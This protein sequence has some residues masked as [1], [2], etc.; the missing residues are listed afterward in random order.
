[1]ETD[2]SFD[3]IKDCEKFI[4]TQLEKIG[5]EKLK[6][7]LMDDMLPQIMD[8]IKNSQ[9]ITVRNKSCKNI[10]NSS[11]IFSLQT[12]VNFLRNEIQQKNNIITY[13]LSKIEGE[14]ND[15]SL[16]INDYETQVVHDKQDINVYDSNILDRS[17]EVVKSIVIEKKMNDQLTKVRKKHH[18]LFLERKTSNVSEKETSL[19]ET[20]VKFVQNVVVCGDSIVNGL[21]SKGLSN[22]E[23]KTVVRS[24]PGATSRDMV[25]FI[26]PHIKSKPDVFILHVGTN[27]MTK[28][29][30]ST[31]KNIE[32]IIKYVKDESPDTNIVLS[33]V[34][35]RK[36]K[37]LESKRKSI[38]LDL[39]KIGN[40]CNIPIIKNSN[41]DESCLSRKKLHLNRK[42]LA[43]LAINFKNHLA[44][45][46]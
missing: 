1:M 44:K 40:Y 28:N 30:S 33:D 12:E 27:D 18:S 11:E 15:L 45:K 20:Q 21:D 41:I 5:Y 13:L 8:T 7:D 4:D 26:K 14:T 46:D 25:D 17:I 24:F 43:K 16:N 22:K 36:D 19:N 23:M 6:R 38:N 42:G 9:N 35:F 2:K 3:H 31:Y 37:D 34:C 39:D 29:V 32:S 10:N